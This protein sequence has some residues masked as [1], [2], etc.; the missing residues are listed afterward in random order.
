[1]AE[2][3]MTKE[4]AFRLSLV[5]ARETGM[6]AHVLCLLG[7]EMQQYLPDVAREFCVSA[8][9]GRN[10]IVNFLATSEENYRQTMEAW[11]NMLSEY[12]SERTKGA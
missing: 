6:S 11:R 10:F 9:D 4:E 7:S 5:V 2:K 12:D 3:A 1:M 8:Q